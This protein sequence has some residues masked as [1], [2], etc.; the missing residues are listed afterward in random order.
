MSAVGF[1]KIFRQ[2]TKFIAGVARINQF[3]KAFL[4]E[5]AFIGKSNV[6]KSSLI[7]TICNNKWLAKVSHTPGRTQQI[8]FFSI[9]EKLVIVDMPGYGFAKV[10]NKLKLDWEELVLYYFKNRSNIKLVNVLIDSRRGI[11]DH[12]KNMIQL[13]ISCGTEIQIVYTKSDKVSSKNE[14]IESTK[15]FLASLNHSCNVIYTSSRSKEGARELQYSLAK[16]IK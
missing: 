14:I 13:I 16:Y 12:D 10:P 6:G 11:K 5:V 9:A 8:N 2:E 15:I 4:P 3:P 1:T 7:N